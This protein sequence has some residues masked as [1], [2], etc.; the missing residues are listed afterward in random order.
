MNRSDFRADI[1]C[2]SDFSDGSD[3]PQALL[4][5][6]K[7]THLFGLS[8][9]DHDTIEAY[10]PDLFREAESL[11]IRLLT[12]VELSTEFESEEIHVLGYGF[13]L[14]ASSLRAFIQEIQRRRAGRNQKILENLHRKGIFIT[15]EELAQFAGSPSPKWQENDWFKGKKIIGRPHI[16]ALMMEKGYVRNLKD[17]FDV[18]LKQGACCYAPGLKFTPL[19]AIQEIRR[20]GGKAILAHPHFIKR[21]HTQKR[22]LSL[23]FDGIECYYSML[24]KAQEA[25]WLQLA[26]KKG[27]IATGG[28]DYHGAFKPH[29]PLGC[30]W[31]NEKTFLQLI[32]R[33]E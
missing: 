32:D 30:S 14:E 15:E 5:L 23:P 29:I 10:T 27:W 20:A 1:H 12:G 6:A 4:Q 17:A 18:Y 19:D 9:T 25:P 24:A 13:D 28:S 3:S 21:G 8:I 33:H 16:A 7:K 11:Q 22:I 31:V 26:E 2:H